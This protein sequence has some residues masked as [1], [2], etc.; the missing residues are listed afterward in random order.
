MDIWSDFIS[1]AGLSGVGH[2]IFTK[3]QVR[4]GFMGV[5]N[6]LARHAAE[7]GRWWRSGFP[8]HVRVT[9][10]TASGHMAG[11]GRSTD[12]KERG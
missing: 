4:G 6:V 3:Q 9:D 10:A 1:W 2:C 5:W 11:Y 12:S 8:R 7:G